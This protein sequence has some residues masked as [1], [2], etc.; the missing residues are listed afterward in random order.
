MLNIWRTQSALRPT[1]SAH[2][3]VISP[4]LTHHLQEKKWQFPER[5]AVCWDF[6]RS[7]SRADSSKWSVWGL[8]GLRVLSIR[9]NYED[10]GEEVVFELSLEGRWLCPGWVGVGGRVRKKVLAGGGHGMDDI[11]PDMRTTEQAVCF[12]WSIR[13]M[14]GK[15]VSDERAL[16]MI[17]T[18]EHKTVP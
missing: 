12:C 3:V 14:K 15:L 18:L 10:L 8:K 13:T 7:Y 5:G 9:N 16:E 17:G 6:D 11:I 2:T 4:V 1:G